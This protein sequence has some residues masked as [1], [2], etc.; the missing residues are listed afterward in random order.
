[1][2]EKFVTFEEFT[3]NLDTVV[4]GFREYALR[5]TGTTDPRSDIEWEELFTD[6]ADELFSPTDAELDVLPF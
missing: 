3:G 2:P 1:M 5:H 4:E 6:F